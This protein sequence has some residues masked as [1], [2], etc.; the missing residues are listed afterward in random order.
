MILLYFLQYFI[1]A[2]LYIGPNSNETKNGS[3]VFPFAD[4]STGLQAFFQNNESEIIFF[5]KESPYICNQSY[6]L[7]KNTTLK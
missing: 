7:S 5:P 6:I 3:Y 1:A 4:F 2:S